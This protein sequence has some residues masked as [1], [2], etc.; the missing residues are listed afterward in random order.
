MWACSNTGL[1]LSVSQS[2]GEQGWTS[3]PG[4]NRGPWQL[5]YV[6]SYIIKCDCRLCMQPFQEGWYNGGCTLTWIAVLTVPKWNRKKKTIEHQFINTRCAACAWIHIK[7]YHVRVSQTALITQRLWQAYM[8]I[9][10]VVARLV[11]HW[12]ILIKHFLSKPVPM[13]TWCWYPS[14]ARAHSDPQQ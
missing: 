7:N 9:F 12:K 1:C 2:S 10:M 4:G 5:L 3:P 13:T 6:A 11:R 14:L 8:P